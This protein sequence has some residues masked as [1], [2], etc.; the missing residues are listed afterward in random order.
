MKIAIIGTGIAGNVVARRLHR[1]HDI[2]VFEANDYVGGHTHTHRIERHGRVFNVDSGFIVFNDRTY[3]RFTALLRELGV[4][5]Q[6]TEMSFSVHCERTGFEYCGSNLNGLFAQ[7]RNLVNP[8]FHGLIRDIL[9][10]NRESRRLLDGVEESITLGEYLRDGGYGRYFIDRYLLPM[11]AAIWST[12][13]A[14]MLA[15]PARFF[16]RFFDNHGLLDTAGRPNWFVVPGGSRTYVDALIAPFRE[17]IRLATPVTRVRRYPD[18][19]E[20]ESSAGPEKFDAVVFACHSD[21]ALALLDDA[22]VA[23]KSVL[24]AIPYQRNSAVLH[25]GED[26]LPRRRRAWSSWNFRLS[27]DDAV[28]P[29]VTY[30]MNRLQS[31]DSDEAFC[32]TLNSDHRVP[33]HRVLAAMTYDHP[34]FTLAG[35]A[36]QGRQAEI[37][38]VNRSFFCGAYWRNGFHEDG[39]VS[40]LDAVEHF[41]QW[42]ERHEH[43]AVRRAG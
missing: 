32:V 5:A 9:R 2:T 34:L 12:D 31:L 6:P 3:P 10:F 40:A 33:P 29:A 25:V 18:R 30:Y 41:R 23:E 7:R 11:G 20:L 28:R 15:F 39:V 4:A 43:L 37:N 16:V 14:E 21:Q 8:R 26:R 19:V 22:D 36:A 17:R 1:D 13:V 27:A 42:E 38:G 24:G 35:V